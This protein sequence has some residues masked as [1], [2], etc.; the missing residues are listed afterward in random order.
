MPIP[1][2]KKR[3]LAEPGDEKLSRGEAII[4]R[5]GI[6]AQPHVL[7]EIN[8]LVR[9]PDVNFEEVSQLVEQDVSLSAKVIKVASSPFF[10]GSNEQFRSV[11]AALLKLGV[12]HFANGV[13]SVALRESF[14]KF[15]PLAKEFWKHSSIIARISQE[16]AEMYQPEY[17]EDAYTV[18]LFHDMAAVMLQKYE[19]RYRGLTKRALLLDL[20]VIEDE[21]KL[22]M[23]DHASVGYLFAKSWSIPAQMLDAIHYHHSADY[24]LH[25][26]QEARILKAILQLAELFYNR[27]TDPGQ[28]YL[29]GNEAQDALLD[30]ICAELEIDRGNDLDELDN[31]LVPLYA[32]IKDAS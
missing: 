27:E 4:R 30:T 5:I 3:S 7:M 15:G 18:G 9:Q 26:K 13:M 6:P 32:D 8:R 17:A 11:K 19:F 24:T 21:T 31:V 12:K 28:M 10:G 25:S 16:I 23:S 2:P 1:P 14:E 29:Y 20:G 22:L